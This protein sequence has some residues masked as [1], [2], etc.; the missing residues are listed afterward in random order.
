VLPVAGGIM[1]YLHFTLFFTDPFWIISHNFFHSLVIDSLIMIVGYVE[2]RARRGWGAALFWLAVS[3]QFH[4]IIDIFTHHI[5]GP[6]FLFPLSWH[7]RF[8]STISYWE[9]GYYG[10]VFAWF[11]WSLNAL[12]V[13]YF[14][15]NWLRARPRSRASL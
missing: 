10:Q 1:E 14:G 8:P 5:D 4:T 6:L 12:I 11:E 9:V 15:I 7:Y 2:F 3:L 13:I